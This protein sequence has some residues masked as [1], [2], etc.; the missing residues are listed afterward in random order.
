MVENQGRTS[1]VGRSKKVSSQPWIP[2]VRDEMQ[3]IC[4]RQNLKARCVVQLTLVSALVP[5]RRS[6]AKSPFSRLHS[7]THRDQDSKCALMSWQ[8][9][10]S[11]VP[12]LD[13][14]PS[15][16]STTRHPVTW[17]HW[18]QLPEHLASSSMYPKGC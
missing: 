11:F 16:S 2:V 7:G 8:V 10:I 1:T 12:V 15:L 5:T 6:S 18:H 9:G 3:F 13:V 14:T 4:C 17:P